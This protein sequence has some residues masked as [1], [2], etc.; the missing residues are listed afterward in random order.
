ML[1]LKILMGKGAY[2][3]GQ[4]NRLA[5]LV[6]VR[7]AEKR[8]LRGLTQA[9]LAELLGINQVSLSR[10]ENGEISPRFSRLQAI[11]NALSCPVDALFRPD[12]PETARKANVIA[13]IVQ[14]LPDQF[15][16][17]VLAL[18]VSAAS[19]MRNVNK[20]KQ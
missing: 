7:I 18:V 8:R 20:D 19:L 1:L 10:M 16:E 11:A 2:M 3:G 15:Q 5:S 13:D 4:K 6:G 17:V 9:Q 12:E 14:S